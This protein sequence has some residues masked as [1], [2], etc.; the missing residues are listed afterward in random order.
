MPTRQGKSAF[1][2]PAGDNNLVTA[3]RRFHL[4]AN[5]AGY[6][7][8][9]LD[10]PGVHRIK[11]VVTSMPLYFSGSLTTRSVAPGHAAQPYRFELPPSQSAMVRRVV[12]RHLRNHKI[13]KKELAGLSPH[14]FLGEFG[15]DEVAIY[16]GPSY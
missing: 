11:A 6:E 14:E 5:G 10:S 13:T 2:F 1:S 16:V 3:Q 8:H 4:P 9:T 7:F 15:Q 12:E